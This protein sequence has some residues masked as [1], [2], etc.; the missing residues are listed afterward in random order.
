M[1]IDSSWMFI[2]LFCRIASK[3]FPD[4]FPD[5]RMSFTHSSPIGF[6]I[7]PEGFRFSFTSYL[8]D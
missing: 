5:T 4:V 1:N 3:I 7:W 6:K 2:V 8:G